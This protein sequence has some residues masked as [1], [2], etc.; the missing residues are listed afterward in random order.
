M[1]FFDF[2]PMKKTIFHFLFILL[3]GA[4]GT[5]QELDYYISKSEDQLES[6]IATI[7]CDT[8]T[9][10]VDKNILVDKDITIHKNIHTIFRNSG[11]FT[12]AKGNTLTLEGSFNSECS[13]HIFKGEGTVISQLPIREVYPEWWGAQSDD[14][15]I[16]TE[17]IQFA[18]DFTNQQKGGVVKFN[19]GTY[20]IDKSIRMKDYVT[21]M[22][23][24]SENG[25]KRIPKEDYSF[26]SH[27][28]ATNN[29]N[30]DVVYIEGTQG[31]G[32]ENLIIDGNKNFQNKEGLHCVKS[33]SF[34]Q[35]IN[36]KNITAPISFGGI[37]KGCKIVNPVN[38]G[39]FFVNT[40]TVEISE[41]FIMSGLFMSLG[42]DINVT[43]C[44]IDGTHGKHPSIYID[45]VTDAN[46]GDNLIWGWGE[47]AL[48]KYRPT[49]DYRVR[50][51]YVS[52]KG[53]NLSSN[54]KTTFYSEDKSLYEGKP[55]VLNFTSSIKPTFVVR[56]TTTNNDYYF[57]A[58]NTFFL[59]QIAKNKWE[60][61]NNPFNVSA[62]K[63]IHIN[64]H[65]EP[66][67][68]SIESGSESAVLITNSSQI[69][70]NSNRVACSIASGL[71]C[72]NSNDIMI[73][74]NTFN[75]I[76]LAHY[77]KTAAI[78]LFDSSYC[79]VMGNS[80]GEQ[81]KNTKFISGSSNM[82][83]GIL[84]SDKFTNWK[85]GGNVIGPNQ[86]QF[87]KSVSVK[88]EFKGDPKYKNIIK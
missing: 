46:F 73:N 53:I 80:I 28:K 86:Y 70:L 63:K 65:I 59:H 2:I 43:A 24:K 87:T 60:F 88:D 45:R 79:I 30:C 5:S 64:R 48:K 19:K 12:V 50:N 17:A 62:S 34:D 37:I 8:A 76:N 78:E 58:G 21:L 35:I 20:L 14:D 33:I 54:N 1:A 22:G 4:W 7:E 49:V 67:T 31:W 23:I 13:F 39:V 27:I 81:D 36:N 82:L 71:T 44:S 32:I 10:I 42:A 25:W 83:Y 6:I 75:R 38:Y 57:A 69:R 47:Y 68:F 3:N 72:H 18:I 41:N 9:L 77:E 29:S 40:K 56:D 52:L 51:N 55:V 16:D 66:N 15:S 26:G 61:R 11:S 85:V 74:S 84:L